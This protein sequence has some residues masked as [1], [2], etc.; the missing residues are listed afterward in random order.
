MKKIVTGIVILLVFSAGVAAQQLPVE[1]QQKISGMKKLEAIMKVVEDFYK[2]EEEKKEGTAGSNRNEKEEFENGLFHWKRWEYFNKTRLSPNGELEDV[3]ARTIAAWN[4]VNSKYGAAAQRDANG[5]QSSSDAAWNF[6]GPFSNAYQNGFYRGQAR[7]DRIVFHPTNPNTFFV[8]A[9]NGGLWRTENNGVSWVNLTRYFPIQSISGVAVDPNNPQRIFVLTGDGNGGGAIRQNSCGIWF[10]LNGGA[11]WTKTS[12][13]SSRQTPVF[14]GFKLVMMPGNANTLFAATGSGLFRSTDGGN[15]WVLMFTGNTLL[16]DGTRPV[17][18]IEFDP[19][20]ASTIYVSSWGR[21]YRSTDGGA[22]FPA[23]EQTA[24]AGTNRIEIGVSASNSNYVYLLCSPFTGSTSFAGIYRSVLKGS[25]NS[26]GV[27]MATSPNILSAASN[28]IAAANDG[29]QSNYNLAIAANPTNAEMIVVAGKIV[30]RSIA[31]GTAPVNL[32][33][34][35]EPNTDPVAPSY[36]IHPDIHD[37]AYNPLNNKLYCCNDGGVYVSSDNGTAWV[38]ITNGINSTTFYHMSAAAYDANKIMG[39]TQDNGMKYKKN[40]GDFLHVFGGDGFDCAFGNS[41]SSP[42]YATNNAGV[43]KYNNNGDQLSVTTPANTTNLF[44]VITVNPVDD[45]IVYLAS[46]STGVSKSTNGG[47]NWSQVLNLAI[48]QS[49]CNCPSNSNRIYVA[50][51]SGIFRTDNAGTN[52]SAN[53]ANNSGFAGSG[54]IADV[55]VC[56]ANS[57][58][59]YAVIGG[60]TAG[61]KVLTSND[62]GAT[63]INISGTLP[64]EVNVNCVTVDNN[65]NAYI[66]TDMG[67]YYKAPAEADWTPYF[68]ELPRCPVTDLVINQAAG[69][70]RASTYGAGIWETNVYSACD[71][72]YNIT[73]DVNGIVYGSR[74]YQASDNITSNATITGTDSTLVTAR[75]GREIVLGIG[76]TVTETQRFN[77]LLGPCQSGLLPALP[78]FSAPVFAAAADNGNNL[79]RYPYGTVTVETGTTH[80]TV[81]TQKAG[82]YKLVLTDALGTGIFWAENITAESKSR[83]TVLIDTKKIKPGQYFIQLIFDNKLVHYQEMF[84]KN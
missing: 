67:V 21:F 13:N 77:G 60:Y 56:P 41:A 36:Y 12:F 24:I 7:T 40:T 72:S 34:F 55:N 6:I 82:V 83:N 16:T 44:P 35:A 14:N 26:F 48:Q 11:N 70:I 3:A 39:G 20:N 17:Y 8:C 59:V 78:A 51:V 80:C 28:G 63:W 1:L 38:N 27:A 22:T 53:L 68:N 5:V 49:I 2:E 57:N 10:T 64:A 75:A 47:S 71:F 32:T 43:V 9:S 45:N 15:T 30:W 50:G 66:G 79:A 52:W 18:D 29:D 76:F 42:I 31:G 19:S 84:V 54:R 61:V 33:V 46:S 58:L 69:K 25:Q 37:L 74:F 23:S 73:G 65:N 81:N 4:I 62:A